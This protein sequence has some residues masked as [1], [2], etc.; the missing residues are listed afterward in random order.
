MR[1]RLNAAKID[2]DEQ[3]C[4][5]LNK[6]C[7]SYM[8]K[9]SA[10][11]EGKY[12]MMKKCMVAKVRRK[13][14]LPDDETGNPLR[15]YTNASESMNS[16]MKAEKNAFLRE[17]PGVSKLS[18]LQFTR[19]VFESIHERQQEEVEL[20]IAGLSEEYQLYSRAS[21]LQVPVEVWFEWHEPERQAFIRKVNELSAEE[22]LG[23]KEVPWPKADQA[24]RHEP[25]FLE[26]SVDLAQVLVTQFGYS[27]DN[28]SFLEEEV[29]KLVNHPNAIQKK[30]SLESNS[31]SEFEVASNH[32]KTGR[33][34][35]TVYRDHTRCNCG[36]YRHDGICSHSLAIAT[37]A[38]ILEQHFAF[39]SK[40]RKVANRSALAEH[41]V[42]HEVAGKKG[43]KNKFQYRQRNRNSC[44]R[45][46]ADAGQGYT[47]IHHNDHPF[48]LQM[49]SGVHKSCKSCDRDFCHKRRIIPFDLVVS[50]PERW[51]YPVN[52][53]WSNKRATT[54]E[55]TRYYH[56]S[57]ACILKRFPYFSADEYLRFHP[58]LLL[59]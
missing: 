57:K 51:Y 18:K 6:T 21:H 8:P 48:T 12:T 29:R 7:Q 30:P 1:Q 24:V 39:L 27:S 38:L 31:G 59:F 22:I 28:A 20:A 45:A 3:E 43:G 35:V 33:V 53:D 40:K 52:G 58:I 42:N 36:R 56:A 15:C 26:P 37:K 50:H 47:E 2:M 46:E 4:R 16:V 11:L 23:K 5:I 10:F 54:R 41:S 19:H 14:G 49:L 17:N 25:E 34:Q 9:Y 32:S 44:D 13:A 55:T